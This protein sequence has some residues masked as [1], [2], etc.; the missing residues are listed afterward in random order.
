[1][2]EPLDLTL[3]QLFITSVPGITSD[4]QV[5]FQPPDEDWR[6]YVKNLQVG[7]SSVNAINVYLIDLRENRKLRSNERT[8]EA[9]NGDVLE[10]QASRRVDCH[11][12]ISTWSPADVTPA[13]EPTLDE[14]A[15]L[16]DVVDALAANDPIVP[17]Q[18]FAPAPPPAPFADEALPIVLLPTEGFP[19]LA[20]FWGTMGD[21]HRWKPCVQLI[22][23][24]PLA[25]QVYRMGATVTTVLAAAHATPLGAPETLAVIGGTVRTGA[26]GVA[27]PGAWVELLRLPLNTRLQLVRAD[28][29]GRF[30]FTALQPGVQYGL[31]A[32]SA[33]LG[34]TPIRIID[35]PSPTGEYDLTL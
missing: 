13:I 18:I 33:T 35:V 12:L 16:Y 15:V 28:A 9:V 29:D 23:T 3:R 30:R 6:T 21:K 26:P 17:A 24:L 1:M 20:E 5:R 8:R 10:S 34:P 19:K 25:T 32:S 22:V 4:S 31:R 2:I 7:G 11:Y 14:H 27:V